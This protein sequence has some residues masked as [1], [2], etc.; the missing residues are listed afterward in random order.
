MNVDI[1]TYRAFFSPARF[2]SSNKM[3]SYEIKCLWQFKSQYDIFV[4]PNC[5]ALSFKRTIKTLNKIKYFIYL[6]VV[7]NSQH[8]RTENI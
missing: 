6:H 1:K 3:L 5:A 2:S 8:Q 7:T 4:C